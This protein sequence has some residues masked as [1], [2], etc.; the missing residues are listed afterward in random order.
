MFCKKISVQKTIIVS[1]ATLVSS[2]YSRSKKG[3]FTNHFATAPQVV[4]IIRYDC[5]L[6][7]FLVFP[8]LIYWLDW[9][10]W[11]SEYKVYLESCAMV[12]CSSFKRVGEFQSLLTCTFHNWFVDD[13][14]TRKYMLKDLVFNFSVVGLGKTTNKHHHVSRWRTKC[15]VPIP[16]GVT[17]WSDVCLILLAAM[18]NFCHLQL[19]ESMLW[20]PDNYWS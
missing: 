5:A 1:V 10:E 15:G 7:R 17:K 13:H 9:S 8:Q 14:A 12:H 16:L 11:I 3:A 20:Y 2:N 6:Y 19:H 18:V 4:N